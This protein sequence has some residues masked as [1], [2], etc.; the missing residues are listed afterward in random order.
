MRAH[1]PHCLARL[2]SIAACVVLVRPWQYD[3]HRLQSGRLVSPRIWIVQRCR[4]CGIITAA[5]L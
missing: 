4:T 5:L 2:D 3:V 1:V